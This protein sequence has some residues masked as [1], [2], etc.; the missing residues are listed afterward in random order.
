MSVAK[1]VTDSALL[2]EFAFKQQAV[3]SVPRLADF[4]LNRRGTLIP[5]RVFADSVRVADFL[6]AVA[7]GLIIAAMYVDE[8]LATRAVGYMAAVGLTAGVLVLCFDYLGLY[9][10]SKFS[11]TV[12]QLPRIVFGWMVAVGVLAAA[13]FFAKVGDDFSRVWLAGWLLTGMGAV[14]LERIAVAN[15]AR[16]WM[17]V[18]RLYRRAVIYGGGEQAN[19]VIKALEADG[20]ADIRIC[21]VFDDRDGDRVGADYLGYP[22]LGSISSLIEVA[23][24]TRIDL[25]IVAL[26]LSAEERI[27]NVVK[28]VSQ[29][30]V[31]VKLPAK[32]SQVR[33]APETY[34]RVGSVAMLDL[35]DKPLTA[36]GDV[37]KWLF[38]K[39]IAT[40]ALILLSPVLAAVA[41]AV[42]MDSRGP[43]LFRQKRY[44]LNN[45]LIE[46]F[47]F[48]SMYVDMCDAAASKLVTK[49]DPRVTPVGRFI[50]KSSLDELPQ[51][52]NVLLGDLSLV[53]PRPHAVS[54]KAGQELYDQVVESYFARHKVKPGITGWAQINGWRGETDTH[55]KIVKRV[56]HDLYYIENWSIFF[57]FYILAKTPLA[58]LKTENSY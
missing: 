16:H 49:E 55:E 25:V 1:G 7:S 43:I 19:E 47:K 46:V 4:S 6:V 12:Y 41:V 22:V 23:R 31:E 45:E 54:A 44:G 33:F 10:V 11:S 53:G 28:H 26:P 57:D 34:S 37:G 36:W 58:L 42:K 38:D 30:P 3:S 13:V 51:L 24:S 35:V 40:I 21:G 8:I 32:L 5:R 27:A 15:L 29:L 14:I 18:G 48:R 17:Q 56:E 9:R 20:D 50:R 2:S 39:V 52:F